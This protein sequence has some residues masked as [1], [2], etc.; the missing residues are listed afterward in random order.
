MMTLSKMRTKRRIEEGLVS[1]LT[2]IFRYDKGGS[3]SYARRL[4]FLRKDASS[5]KQRTGNKR[6]L[7]R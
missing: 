1:L 7:N 6:E 4:G 2:R 3:A 5:Q